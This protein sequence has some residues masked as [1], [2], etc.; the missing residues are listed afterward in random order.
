MVL[1]I[2]DL[3][4]INCKGV[5]GFRVIK[6]EPKKEHKF[7]S[8]SKFSNVRSFQ[9]QDLWQWERSLKMEHLIETQAHIYFV[10]Y[11]Y[12]QAQRHIITYDMIEKANIHVHSPLTTLRWGQYGSAHLIIHLNHSHIWGPLWSSSDP[13]MIHLN[14]SYIWDPLDHHQTP[15][16]CTPPNVLGRW[17]D[18]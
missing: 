5:G 14:H 11:D 18:D 9:Y 10:I 7:K 12:C 3:F 8:N 17:I 2:R 16:V 15:G 6:K 4:M 13:L 1:C